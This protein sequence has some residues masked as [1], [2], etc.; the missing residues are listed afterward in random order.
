[1]LQ[2]QPDKQSTL[3]RSARLLQQFIVDM[4]IKIE[5]TRLDFVCKNLHVIHSDLY[6][7]VWDG[8]ASGETRASKAG[9]HIVLPP[10]FVGGPRAMKRRYLDA[11]ML[12]QHYGKPDIF[13]T[14]TC[15]PSWPEI[16][17]ELAPGEEAQNRP[18]LVA[19]I[20]HAKLVTLKEEIVSD[21][22]FGPVAAF[23]Y[24]VEFQKRGLPH[25]HFLI[26]LKSGVGT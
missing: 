23:V 17:Q 19:R 6:E 15:N 18:D 9:K 20:F 14:M 21:K 13:L 26:I 25:A 11:M 7:G 3:L 1:M 5:S 10:S 12:V 2:I 4:Y 8:I 24:V 16:I 22:L